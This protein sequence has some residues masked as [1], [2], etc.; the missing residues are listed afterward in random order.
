[1]RFLGGERYILFGT[2]NGDAQVMDTDSG[3]IIKVLT[4]HQGPVLALAIS[5]KR[6]LIATGG[7]DG[8]IRV[9]Q[10]SKWAPVQDY[11][12]NYGPIW[13]LGFSAD[14]K[15]IYY[16]GLDDHVISWQ[17][18]PRK[19][20][21][22]VQSKYLR[23]FQVTQHLSLGARQ[24]ARKCS[25][26]HTLKPADGNRAGPTLHKL[27]GRKAGSVANYPYSKGL[28]ESNIV[29]NEKTIAQLFDLGPDVFTP[30]SKMPLQVLTD[31]NAR[32][33]LIAFLKKAT[34]NNPDRD[35]AVHP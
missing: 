6:R 15:R 28:R 31:L 9:W 19:P 22:N 4:P 24:F 30:G 20:F 1:M 17:I 16:S 21:E 10:I 34:T 23:R 18:K 27:F 11:Q 25:V 33:A 32:T 12:S 13:S 7:G 14:A 5:P 35:R 8:F 26:C 29:W 3:D 2:L